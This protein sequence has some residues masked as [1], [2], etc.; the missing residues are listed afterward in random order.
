MTTRKT[1]PEPDSPDA[2]GTTAEPAALEAEP[3][4]LCREPHYLP[5]LAPT[6]TCQLPAQVDLVIGD[7]GHEHRHQDGDALYVWR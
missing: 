7:A 2:D 3:Q 6:V 5:V 4:P 1:K